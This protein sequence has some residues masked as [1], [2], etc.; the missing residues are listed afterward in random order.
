MLLDF[1]LCL[2]IFHFHMV[3]VEHR[4]QR[5]ADVLTPCVCVCVCIC[6]CN[7]S[8]SHSRNR[9]GSPPSLFFFVRLLI[10]CF[11]STNVFRSRLFTFNVLMH[12]V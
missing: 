8:T 3:S 2:L 12:G 1:L 10:N 5:R 11:L 9:I 6:L 4:W 7:S